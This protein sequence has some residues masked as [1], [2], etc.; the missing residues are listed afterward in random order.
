M[1]DLFLQLL[2]PLQANLQE[3]TLYGVRRDGTMGTL[4]IGPCGILEPHAPMAFPQF[5]L[6]QLYFHA[7]LK[8][9]LRE[10]GKTMDHCR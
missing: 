10:T 4:K 9:A 5:G 7:Q 6:D 3:S 1:P 8:P 2:E